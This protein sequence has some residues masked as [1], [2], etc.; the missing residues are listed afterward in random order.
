MKAEVLYID[1]CENWSPVGEDLRAAL[2]ATGNQDAPVAFTLIA[3]P[4]QAAAAPF[5]G[6]PTILIDGAD[7]FPGISLIDALA[8]RLYVGIDRLQG[9]PTRDQIEH[10]ILARRDVIGPS[11][12]GT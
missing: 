5:A 12:P 3:S 2:D 4:E 11:R 10:A 1:G 7:L 8:C 9:R 6:S